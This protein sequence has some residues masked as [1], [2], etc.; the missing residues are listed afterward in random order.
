MVGSDTTLV[1]KTQVFLRFRV[2][3]CAGSCWGRTPRTVVHDKASYMVA[4]RSQRLASAAALR[5]A[6]LRSWLGSE[7]DGCSGLAGRL[8]DVYPGET[9]TNHRR[10]G[11]GHQFP[12]STPG[13]TRGRFAGRIRKVHDYMNSAEFKARD[14]GGLA[15][16]P[17]SLIERCRRVVELKGKRFRT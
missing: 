5:A 17:E 9:V 12:R 2:G 10:R 6:K 16:L 4:P 13:E 14:G 11:L 8:R 3:S 7:D 15:S 1:Q